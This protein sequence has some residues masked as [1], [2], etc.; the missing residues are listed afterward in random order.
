MKRKC[1]RENRIK[2]LGNLPFKTLF[3]DVWDRFAVDFT[4][5]Q[6]VDRDGLHLFE[7]DVWKSASEHLIQDDAHRIN[8][9]PMVDLF[10]QS[11]FRGE[12]KRRAEDTLCEMFRFDISVPE[13]FGDTKIEDLEKEG[14]FFFSL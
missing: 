3:T 12:I 7:A 10:I 9:G 6:V 1:S 14:I 4:R 11:L 8:V 13:G 2:C 5:D